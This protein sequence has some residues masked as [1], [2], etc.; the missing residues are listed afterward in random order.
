MTEYRGIAKKGRATSSRHAMTFTKRVQDCV[1]LSREI[2]ELYAAK[3]KDL[4]IQQLP[5]QR[6]N[7][8]SYCCRYCKNGR[9]VFKDV[10]VAPLL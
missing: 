4:K 7:F 6:F 1:L 8:Y 2:E 9:M 3:C 5:E 10:L